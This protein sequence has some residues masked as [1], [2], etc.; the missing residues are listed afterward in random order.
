MSVGRMFH[1]LDDV[2][3]YNMR[4]KRDS[5]WWWI[6]MRERKKYKYRIRE[7]QGKR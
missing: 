3:K 7:G 4:E 5:D 1:V 2:N 6:I